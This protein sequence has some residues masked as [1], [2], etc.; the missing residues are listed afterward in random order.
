MEK[1]KEKEKIKEKA[2]VKVKEKAREKEKE[3]KEKEKDAEKVAK[4]KERATTT[5]PI[6]TPSIT[7]SAMTMAGQVTRPAGSKIGM[8]TIG[9]A[10]APRRSQSSRMDPEISTL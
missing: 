5:M 10:V 3:V 4:E 7:G 9:A 1:E 8:V 6:G 2:K